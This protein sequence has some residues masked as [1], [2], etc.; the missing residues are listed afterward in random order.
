L[1]IL[2]NSNKAYN[3]HTLCEAYLD[4]EYMM[5]DFTYGVLGLL[6]KKYSVKDLLKQPEIVKDIYSSKMNSHIDL[7]YIEGLYDMAAIAEYDISKKHDYSISEPNEYYLNMMNLSHDGLWKMGEDMKIDNLIIRKA[8]I[9]D[10]EGKGYVHYQSWIETYTGLFPDEV[11]ERLSLEKS[12]DNARKYPENT[13]V[14]IVDDKIIGFSCY[15]ESRDEDLEDTGE[16]MAIYILK[17]YQ[18]NGVGKKLMEVCYK[19]LSQYSKLSLWVLGDNKKSVGF[20]EKEGFVA[21][22]KTKMLHG[23]EVIRMI[24]RM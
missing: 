22:G 13:Y 3:G 11:M 19:E 8:T 18:G 24:K 14:A 1:A 7:E 16:I 20:Y 23:K 17:E 9:E 2:V 6:S 21:D 10:A 15:L 5:V 4:N 12:I